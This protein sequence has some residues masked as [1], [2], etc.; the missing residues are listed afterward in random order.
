MEDTYGIIHINLMNPAQLYRSTNNINILDRSLVAEPF[1]MAVYK[2]R[3][4]DVAPHAVGFGCVD[5]S[6]VGVGGLYILSEH[7]WQK[8]H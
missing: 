3:G 8:Q 7:D 1:P 5:D 4:E 6:R 2:T